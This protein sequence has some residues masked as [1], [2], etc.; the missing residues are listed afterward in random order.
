LAR[1]IA[2]REIGEAGD[3]FE[4]VALPAFGEKFFG[5]VVPARIAMHDPGDGG[6][7]RAFG[8][9]ITSERVVFDGEASHGPGGRIEAHGFRDDVAGVRKAGEIVES[10]S[11]A[12]KDGGKFGV[13]FL[14]DTRILGEEHPGPGER[15]G[16]GF[17]PGEEKSESFIA[18]L[19][20]GHAGAVFILGVDEEGEEITGVVVRIAALLDDAVDDVGEIADG[21]FGLAIAARR[22]P[23]RSHKQAA[24][25]HC[26]FEEDLEVLADLRGVAL[27]IGV[28]ESFADDLESETHHGI[29]KIDLLAVLP[30]VE[31]TD[32]AIGHG[33]GVVGDAVAMKGWLHHAALTEPE[34]AF[35]GK[36]AV[37][38]KVA[39]G[40]EDAAFDEF[41][42]VV[43]DHVFD[44]VG[45]KEEVGAK[46]EEAEADNV[47]VIMG[48]AGHEA[49]RVVAE[50]A[51]EA[52]EETLFGAGRVK[53][54]GEMVCE[55]GREWKGEWDVGREGGFL[56]PRTPL[57]MTVFLAGG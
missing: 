46:V 47:A 33:G 51:A 22:E 3:F 17:V 20:G 39:I 34:I 19:L 37:A 45:M 13:E 31:E 41:A 44:L 48:G 56:A 30:G 25:I 23:A 18:K 8:N 40:A 29:V 10:G 28:E 52:V 1:A 7:A 6:D 49:E 26:V 43:D 11:A 21:A 15:A 9:R 50:R 42:G 24:K 54:H 57:G 38:E 35:T 32:G 53:G 16:S 14:F 4:E 2:E 27:D 55:V 12:V 36:E 5:I